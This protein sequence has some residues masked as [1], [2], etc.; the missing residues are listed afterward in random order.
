MPHDLSLN[1]DNLPYHH[2]NHYYFK[3]S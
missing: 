1:I 2:Q 3:P